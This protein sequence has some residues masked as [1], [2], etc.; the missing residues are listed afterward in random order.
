[1]PGGPAI[2][3][4]DDTVQ[5]GDAAGVRDHLVSYARARDRRP[6]GVTPLDDFLSEPDPG[7]A[8]SLWFG[9]HRVLEPPIDAERLTAL[10]DADIARID[11]L[12]SVQIDAVLHHPRFQEL[13]AAWLGVR[14]LVAQGEGEPLVR[15]KLFDANW[16]LVCRDLE[17]DFDQSV[18]W[19]RIYSDQF[20]MAGGQPF[21]LLVGLYEVQHRRD[22]GHPTDD[23]SALTGLCQIAAAS[24]APFIV[25]AAP[26]LLGLT[27]F[28]RLEAPMRL[29]AFDREPEYVRWNSLRDQDDSRF[30]GIT[31]PRILLRRPWEDHSQRVDGFRYR[32]TITGRPRAADRSPDKLLWGPAS[33]AFGAVVIRAFRDHR[34]FAAIR[35]APQDAIAGGLVHDLPQCPFP[36]EP[37]GAAIRPG[38]DVAVS[39]RLELELNRYGLMVLSDVKDTNYAVFRGCPSLQRPKRYDRQAA[40]NNARL[41][42]MLQYMLCTARFSHYVKVIMRDRVGSFANPEDC[43]RY[44]NRWLM[45]F[46]SQNPSGASIEMQARRPLRDARVAVREVPGSPGS[47]N[48]T[49]QFLPHFQLDTI[50]TSLKLV[51]QLPRARGA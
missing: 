29:D 11:R 19:Q 37:H 41:S 49:F 48:A 24:F 21:G 45:D 30:L 33:I 20:D 16:G 15:I 46:V 44:L 39:D 42:T 31:V 14:Y 9:K 38:T 34:W 1:M 17:R 12:L 2:A 6:D 25:G 3:T 51:T 47:Y 7:V 4:R 23:V 13:E 26:G 18:L 5:A 32:E 50:E 36:T 10:L 8:L 40:T 43:E 35:G 22:G 27:D 28:V